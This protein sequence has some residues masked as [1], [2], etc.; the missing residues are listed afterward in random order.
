MAIRMP[1]SGDASGARLGVGARQAIIC[2]L[3]L[4]KSDKSVIPKRLHLIAC[5]DVVVRSLVACGSQAFAEQSRYLI[6]RSLVH[7][8]CNT[9]R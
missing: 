6:V 7:G 8:P 3:D 9:T 5:W 2:K 4:Y 1:C